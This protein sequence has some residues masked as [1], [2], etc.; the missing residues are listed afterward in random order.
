[1][2]MGWLRRVDSLQLYVSFAEYRLF[3][4]AVLQ[5][6]PFSLG[7]LLILA[8]PKLQKDRHHKYMFYIPFTDFEEHWYSPPPFLVAGLL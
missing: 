7:S 6:K 5:K 8:T 1:M 4:R 2:N 3:S